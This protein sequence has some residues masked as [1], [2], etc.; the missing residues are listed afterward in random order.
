LNKFEVRDDLRGQMDGT[1]YGKIVEITGG[2]IEKL[3]NDV[4]PTSFRRFLVEM[5][6]IEIS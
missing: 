1:F 2:L 3:R 4:K 5:S 6:L